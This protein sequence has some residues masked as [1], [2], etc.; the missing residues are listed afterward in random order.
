MMRWLGGDLHLKAIAF[1]LTLTIFL[2]VKEEKVVVRTVHV[3]VTISDLIGEIVVLDEP[4]DITLTLRGSSRAFSRLDESQLR[5]LTIGP[6]R[7]D[8]TRWPVRPENFAL[9]PGIEILGLEPTVVRLQPEALVEV[10]LPVVA[11]FRGQVPEGYEV[12]RSA[13]EPDVLRVSMPQSYVGVVDTLYTEAV[14]LSGV[15]RTLER[16]VQLSVQRQFVTFPT[17]DQVTVSVEVGTVER[18]RVAETVPIVVT[19]TEADRCEVG[20]ETMR[21]SI[22]GPVTVVDT[23]NLAEVF[24]TIDCGQWVERGQGVFSVE[25]VVQNVPASLQLQTSPS[26][27]RVRVLPEPEIVAPEAPQEQ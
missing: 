15:V 18:G 4:E 23:V 20:A 24:A 8:T 3:D 6:I 17:G 13:V 2:F 7:A 19:G 11:N 12:L 10:E 25:P 14:E 5:S 22:R 26:V 21:V 1:V 27:V 16:P 9:P